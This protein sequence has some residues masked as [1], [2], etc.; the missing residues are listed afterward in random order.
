MADSTIDSELFYLIDGWPG[1]PVPIEQGSPPEDG[2]TGA[3]HHNVATAAYPIGT[4]IQVYNKDSAGEPGYSIFRYLQV[5][6]QGGAA[7]IAVKSICT[8]DSASNYYK[9]TNDPDDTAMGEEGGPCAVAISAITDAYYG[10]F[11]TG[12]VCP[13]SWVSGLGGTYVT[14]STVDKGGKMIVSDCSADVLGFG[15]GGTDE[16]ICGVACAADAT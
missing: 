13:E 1:V 11:W 8:G 10:W 4:A 7:N 2:F 9:V 14:D 5:G 16:L 6:T 15:I 3:A 12:G